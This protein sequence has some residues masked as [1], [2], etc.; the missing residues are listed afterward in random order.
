MHETFESIILKLLAKDKAMRY[1]HGKELADDLRELMKDSMMKRFQP[2]AAGQT[3]VGMVRKNNEDAFFLEPDK[4]LLVVADGMGGHASG[5]IASRMAVDAIRNYFTDP[6]AGGKTPL[7]GTYDD[8]FTETDQPSGLC[9]APGKH[10]HLRSGAEQRPV[11]G[12]GNDRRLRPS[13]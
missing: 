10:G 3:D 11:A 1:Q 5:E 9:G 8:D 2:L 6:A 13:A 7:I 4:G 12:H